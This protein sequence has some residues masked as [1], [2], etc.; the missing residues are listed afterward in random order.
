MENNL[1]S[2]TVPNGGELIVENGQDY[3]V[4]NRISNDP[5]FQLLGSIYNF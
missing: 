3:Y 2:I 1:K 4:I 5:S